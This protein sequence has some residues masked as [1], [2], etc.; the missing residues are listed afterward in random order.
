MQ[1]GKIIDLPD[2]NGYGRVR[3][4]YGEIYTVRAGEFDKE[5]KEGDNFAYRVNFLS[6][7][8]GNI[9]LESTED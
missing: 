7:K 3:D 6:N 5:A 8:S 9:T 1:V 4:E 2:S